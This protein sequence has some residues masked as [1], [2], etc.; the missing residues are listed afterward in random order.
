MKKPGPIR[1]GNQTSFAAGSMLDPFE[2]ALANGFTAFE[3]FPNRGFSGYDGWDER[4]LND[5]TRRYIRRVFR[6]MVPKKGSLT[7]ME[8]LNVA[9]P[10]SSAPIFVAQVIS[11]DLE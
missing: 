10:E 7:C 4:D 9:V 2:F 6:C 5:E 1:I 3:F 8:L 11:S